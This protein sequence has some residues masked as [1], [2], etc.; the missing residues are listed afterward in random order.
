MRARLQGAHG[1]ESAPRPRLLP[2]PRHRVCGGSRPFPS[3]GARQSARAAPAPRPA[4]P[5]RARTAGS[6]PSGRVRLVPGPR[7]LPEL[8]GKRRA[9][10]RSRVTPRHF[11]EGTGDRFVLS[12][13]PAGLEKPRKSS[14]SIPPSGPRV[15]GPRG[16]FRANPGARSGGR[17]SRGEGRGRAPAERACAVPGLFTCPEGRAAGLSLERRESGAGAAALGPWH[18]HLGSLFR[19]LTGS[20]WRGAPRK[21]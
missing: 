18:R 12:P 20:W 4:P 3:P 8:S 1:N 14:S 15:S 19:S 17:P 10:C 2:A 6:A 5:R 13:R 7:W 21:Q 16:A 11:R 9:L